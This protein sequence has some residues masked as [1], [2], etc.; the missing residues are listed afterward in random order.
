MRPVLTAITQITGWHWRATWVGT[1]TEAIFRCVSNSRTHKV[2]YW[3]TNKQTNRHLAPLTIPE[4]FLS[5]LKECLRNIWRHVYTMSIDI[6]KPCLRNIYIMLEDTFH[7]IWGGVYIILDKVL[8][9]A[10][11]H[12]YTMSENTLTQCMKHINTIFW[13]K[14]TP[15]WKKYLHNVYTMFLS[16]L[17]A[18]YIMYEDMFI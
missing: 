11:M 12:I 1:C 3:L 10:W 17:K 8:H 14:F 13:D 4:Q 15:W 6:Y 2:T 5:C 18:C 7:N 9:Q 16:C